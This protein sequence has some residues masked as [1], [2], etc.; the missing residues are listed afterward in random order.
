[1]RKEHG[2]LLGI[3]SLSE[4]DFKWNKQYMRNRIFLLFLDHYSIIIIV[5]FEEHVSNIVDLLRN[6]MCRK[7]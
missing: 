6:K 5:V 4:N 7:N 3:M 2:Q 1:M